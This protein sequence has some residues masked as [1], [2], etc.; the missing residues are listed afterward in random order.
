MS[1]GSNGSERFIQINNLFSKNF[2][3]SK[4]GLDAGV[5]KTGTVPSVILVQTA[6]TGGIILE[7][8]KASEARDR[9]E[10]DTIK[11][12]VRAIPVAI[13]ANFTAHG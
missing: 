10:V 8:S 7:N 2:S 1:S 11:S 6:T 12:V 9:Q 4:L 13:Q 5:V 3:T